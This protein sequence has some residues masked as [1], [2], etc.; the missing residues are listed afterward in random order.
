MQL[1]TEGITATRPTIKDAD[2]RQNV[3]VLTGEGWSIKRWDLT[4][5]LPWAHTPNYHPLTKE[6]LALQLSNNLEN[7]AVP[8]S[9]LLKLILNY[10]NE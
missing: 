8:S 9:H 3:Q 1:P 6:D 5:T 7:N 10:L 4:E 2:S